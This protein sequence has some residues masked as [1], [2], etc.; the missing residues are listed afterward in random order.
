[1]MRGSSQQ[2]STAGRRNSSRTGLL[3]SSRNSSRGN[4]ISGTKPTSEELIKRHVPPP[5][6][7]DG[8]RQTRSPAPVEVRRYCAASIYCRLCELHAEALRCARDE[9][10]FAGHFQFSFEFSLTSGRWTPQ[11]VCLQKPPLVAEKFMRKKDYWMAARPVY[12][13]Q[14]PHGIKMTRHE[15][16]KKYTSHQNLLPQSKA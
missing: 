16:T 11:L 5:K 15:Q 7:I 4:T 14:R 1:M 3:P 2:S 13:S 9:P 12:V 8:A 10:N 6:T